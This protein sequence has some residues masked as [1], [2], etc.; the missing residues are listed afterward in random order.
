MGG[1]IHVED[2]DPD[3]LNPFHDDEQ[4]QHH[5]WLITTCV[6]G[7]AGS[8][9][10]GTVLLG[11]FGTTDSPSPAL[12]SVNPAEIWQRPA[13]SM[14]SNYKSEGG[15]TQDG[16]AEVAELKPYS[17]VSVV[18]RQRPAGPE[19]AEAPADDTSRASPAPSSSRP[20]R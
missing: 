2:L 11:V 20:G 19:P 4:P 6:A 10:I 17:E 15:A 14:K 1:A 16:E 13:L 12:A 8:L 5:R 9:V 7:V 3:Q 18:F